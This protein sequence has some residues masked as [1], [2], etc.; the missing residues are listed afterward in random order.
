LAGADCMFVVPEDV[1]HLD[2]G[3]EVEVWLLS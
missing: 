3:D 1:D 2:A